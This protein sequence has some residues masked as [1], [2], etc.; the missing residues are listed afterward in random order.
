[1]ALKPEEAKLEIAGHLH[2][3][4]ALHKNIAN[5]LWVSCL[6][7]AEQPHLKKSATIWSNPDPKVLELHHSSERM[8]EIQRIY[9]VAIRLYNLFQK[10]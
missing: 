8:G 9:F 6:A 4:A 2:S 10:E 1:M 7:S 5:C 3:I